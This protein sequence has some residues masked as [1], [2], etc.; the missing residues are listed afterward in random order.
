MNP[1]L[2]T[3]RAFS[4]AVAYLLDSAIGD[5]PDRYHPVAWLGS[6]IG[7]AEHRLRSH[8]A[9]SGLVGGAVLAVSA[10]AVASA[11]AFVLSMA[12]WRLS[13]A[14]AVAVDGSLIWATLA[15]RSLASLGE[16]IADSLEA[17]ELT[18]ARDRV[19]HV[20]ARRTD[21][22]DESGAARAAVE[23]MGENVVDGVIAPLFW[24]GV[25][26]PAG[27]WAHKSASTLDSM[28]GYR[29]EP[30]TRFGTVS[31]RLDDVL[32]WLPARLAI[33]LVPTA[34]A[35]VGLRWRAALRIALRD[36]RKH[37]SPNAAHGEAAFAGALGVRLGG[38][39]PYPGGVVEREPLGEGD[40]PQAGHLW[41]SARL[42]TST[43]TVSAV[44]VTATL[45]AVSTVA[46]AASLSW[47]D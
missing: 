33:L 18:D 4:I 42:V 41:D 44:A 21:A 29:R 5:P 2:L 17:G 38:A 45:L 14:V 39:T 16:G 40:E 9:T 35:V 46:V 30:Y 11:A 27:A 13:P 31:A 22:L 26:G 1:D 25:L 43:A 3:Y 34:A 6:A 12:A 47:P 19:A 20:V 36:R 28:V 24:A 32:A 8:T 15:S 7:W 23:S 10:T 37:E